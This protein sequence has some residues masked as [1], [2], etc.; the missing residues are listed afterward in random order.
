MGALVGVE[1][2]VRWQHQQHGFLS[3]SEFMPLAEQS[4]LIHPVSQWV[5][6][7]ALHQQQAWRALG[8]D[9]PV[10]VLRKAA[11]DTGS[12]ARLAR[13][14]HPVGRSVAAFPAATSSQDRVRTVASAVLVLGM[15][16]NRTP[17]TRR[18]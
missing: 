14:A 5:L 8:M 16:L 11:P 18:R 17:R 3:P 12:S 1:A 10:A 2:L 7:T 6:E 15:R 13:R 4:A 9:I